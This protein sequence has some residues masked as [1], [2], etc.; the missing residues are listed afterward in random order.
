MNTTNE[1]TGLS[2]K[3]VSYRRMVLTEEATKM[4]LI[5]PVISALGY[6]IFNPAEVIPEMVC[7]LS[8]N[9]DKIDYAIVIG[10]KPS[11]LI[12]CK[13]AG[14]ELDRYV[15]QTAK[16]FVASKARF[17]ILTNGT[18]YRFYT[19]LNNKNLM[20]SNAFFTVNLLHPTQ[21]ELK[22]MSKF[23]KDNFNET[24]LIQS[25]R[26]MSHR[27]NLND[28]VKSILSNPTDD[29]VKLLVSKFYDGIISKSV[30]AEFT[31]L[32][33]EAISDFTG[34]PIIDVEEREAE[35]TDD[36][37][38][39]IIEAFDIIKSIILELD[40]SQEVVYKVFKSNVRIAIRNKWHYVCKLDFTEK[41]K[42]IGFPIGDYSHIEWVLIDN[43]QDIY[44]LTEYVHNGLTVAKNHLSKYL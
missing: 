22:F 10:G 29:F 15:R 35:T 27:Q 1:L 20:D 36:I 12:E 3:F 9:S 17:A 13:M 30:I 8:N 11:I 42:R 44:S 26:V 23:S 25:A 24:S 40:N 43:T 37:L 5:L 21:N 18:E 4:A 6:D 14:I 16:Y 32:V 2:E 34:Q 38:P 31:P 7:D 28:E 33:K 41:R 39:E 19:D